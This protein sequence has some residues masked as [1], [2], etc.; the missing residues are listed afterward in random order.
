MGPEGDERR[1][2]F[3]AALLVL[4]YA[5]LIAWLAAAALSPALG[6]LAPGW[7]GWLATPH[8]A[9]AM[10]VGLL[11]GGAAFG[12]VMASRGPALGRTPFLLSAW[13]AASAAPLAMAAYLPC[14][15]DSPPF[16]TAVTSTL[17]LLLGSFEVP[18][19]EGE[20]CHY[21]VPLGLQLARLLAI[22]ATLSGATSVL[23]AVSRSQ[24]DR[25][26]LL[27]AR[28]LTAVVGLD[29]ASWP[30]LQQ[31]AR[32]REPGH[33]TLLLTSDVGPLAERARGAGV[34]V[35]RTG[36]DDPLALGESMPW[37]K[38]ERC[39]LL[40]PDAATNRSRAM[41]LR[42]EVR[43]QTAVRTGR[44]T[45]VVRIDDP[46]HADDWRKRFLGE[47]GVVFDAIGTYEATAEAVVARLRELPRLDEIILTGEAP[48]LLALCAELSQQGREL[49]FLDGAAPLPRVTLIGR[50]AGDV[51]ADH[52]VRQQRF[53]SDPVE[54]TAVNA[55]P[56]LPTV[57]G[58][59]DRVAAGGGLTAVVIARAGTRLGTRL[60][61][62]HPELPVF[63]LA[64]GSRPVPVDE[65]AVGHLTAFNLALA[66]AT[67]RSA[68]AWERA[69]RAV[70]ERY[71]RRFPDAALAMPWAE[72]P[73]EF[74]RDS[75]RR[76][77]HSILDA[78]VALGRSWAPTRPEPGPGPDPDRLASAA[79]TVRIEAGL[80][81]F[82]LN[83]AELERVAE[84]EHESWRRQ[85]L[86]DGWRLG[87]SRDDQRRRHPG[88]KPWAELDLDA[89]RKTMAGVVDTLFALRAL[90]YRSVRPSAISPPSASSPSA[91][92][93][94]LATPTPASAATSAAARTPASSSASAS[95]SAS[96]APT[97]ED[98][99]EYERVG[100]VRADRLDRPLSW[101]SAGGDQL[102]GAPG[103]WVVT[104]ASGGRRTVTDASF[105]A[106][107][108]HLDG[109][110]WQR[111]GRVGVRPAVAGE[112]I[113]TQEGPSVAGSNEWVARD[114]QG[115]QW[116]VPD[117]HL[118]AGYRA[119]GPA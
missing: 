47:P 39:Y 118:R 43:E 9:E 70:H 92:T 12:A 18:F 108:R 113:D 84:Q 119:A 19:G 42:Q 69:A 23:F 27:R 103:D 63:E 32:N 26:G 96:E 34:L 8:S 5:L 46:W 14:T 110:R 105:R 28:R 62:R 3:P 85:Y 73:R 24:L 78:M 45:V 57:S 106:G 112:R 117:D 13:C 1:W 37:H 79:A 86:G 51:A 10:A 89:R 61:V 114:E 25:F 40:S 111:T 41:A 54:L 99:V 100:E 21:P 83:R 72:L 38:V 31:L 101:E 36:S 11:L 49:Q 67:G 74:Y 75:N 64:T 60:A 17:A 68:D 50:D 35:L 93:S 76:Q 87:P 88:L 15:G 7:L 107:H 33:R 91:S 71:R 109:D 44:M 116:I 66:D 4:A 98:W 52:R 6:E 65:P 95:G 82:D 30:V 53:A 104:D 81:F 115:N 56:T 102:V 16:W 58:R 59:L 29:D 2:L 97:S 22:V 20:A 55:I 94:A 80:A 48:L 90:G 77:L